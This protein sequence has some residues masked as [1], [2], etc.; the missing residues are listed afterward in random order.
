[1]NSLIA[2]NWIH[3]FTHRAG[4]RFRRAAALI[5]KAGVV[6]AL[7]LA[8]MLMTAG[9]AA[10]GEEQRPAWSD[11]MMSFAMLT[12]Y[13]AIDFDQSAGWV[14]PG[15]GTYELNPALGKHPTRQDML[16]FGVV[17]IGLLYL[18]S[19]VLPEP[20]GRIVLDSAVSSEQFNIEDNVRA[21][22]GQRLIEAIPIII[23][24]RF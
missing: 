8:V 6:K 24:M 23:T 21:K 19:E 10:H 3:I 17:G 11:R 2:K 4:E 13:A 5:R 20:W 1:M 7:L 12:A 18:A 15:G 22:E 9:S 16:A 14:T